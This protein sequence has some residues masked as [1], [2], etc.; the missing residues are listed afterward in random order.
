MNDQVRGR[1]AFK[2]DLEVFAL[3]SG[4]DVLWCKAR[5]WINQLVSSASDRIHG[6]RLTFGTSLWNVQ[7]FGIF[8]LI[9]LDLVCLCHCEGPLTSSKK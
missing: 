7:S 1:T 2:A 3:A 8:T 9:D 5:F 4:A 6:H